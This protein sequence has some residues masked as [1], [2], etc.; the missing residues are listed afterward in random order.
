MESNQESNV[1][2]AF[3]DRVGANFSFISARKLA[4]T[5]GQNGIDSK[6]K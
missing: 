5:G 1:C 6:N 4:L 2:F 3:A